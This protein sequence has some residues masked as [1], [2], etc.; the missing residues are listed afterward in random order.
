MR[1]ADAERPGDELVPDEA[2]PAVHDRPGVQDRL[3]VG[4]AVVP[5]PSRD[6]VASDVAMVV[7]LAVVS[8]PEPSVLVRHRLVAGRRQVDD[9]E[10]S[11]AERNSRV[12]VP[13]FVI[14]PAMTKN[15]RHAIDCLRPG[16]L[17]ALAYNSADAAHVRF[18]SSAC[19]GGCRLI[20]RFSSLGGS[21][22]LCRLAG[23]LQRLHSIQGERKT[24]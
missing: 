24:A 7:D 14:R 10:T 12:D 1:H 15:G 6:Q 11:V 20:R 22:R 17:R 5:M 13:P 18:G 2:L 4:F 21:G 9:R 16:R 23:S 19:S 3:A 8:Q